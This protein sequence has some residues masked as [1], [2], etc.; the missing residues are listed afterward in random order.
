MSW[1]GRVQPL[2]ES[3]CGGCHGG[4]SP[5]GGLDLISEG[6]YERLL[7]PSV[8]MPDVPLIN[9][10][11]PEGSYLYQKIVGAEGTHK[12]LVIRQG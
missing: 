5:Q 12:A 7:A 3:N 1:L 4:A 8:Q 10:L 2:L 9:P 11:D 6:A